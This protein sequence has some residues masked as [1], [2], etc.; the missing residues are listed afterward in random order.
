M[1]KPADPLAQVPDPGDAFKNP[2]QA[3]FIRRMQTAISAALTDRPG[4][5]SATPM[6]L[7]SSPSG[8]VW[9]IT[10][11]DTGAISAASLR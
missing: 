7:L 9:S 4:A 8:Q 11:S 1:T 6:V 10:V 3:G 2:T 5:N